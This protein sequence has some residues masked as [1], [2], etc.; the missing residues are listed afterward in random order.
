MIDRADP[1]DRL[2]AAEE[3]FDLQEIAVA[4]HGLQWRD[5]G[6]RAQY[7]EAVVA[8]LLGQLA[9]IDLEGG[10]GLAARARRPAQIAPVGGIADQRLVATRELLGEPRDDRLPLIALAFRFGLV[11]AEDVAR[12]A[13]LDLFDE[14]LGLA[15]HPLNEQWRQRRVV[16]EH[17]PAD[18]G[19]AALASAENVLQLAL[20]QRR[21]CGRRDHAAVGDDADPA[22]MKALAQTVDDRQQYGGIG[23]VARQH[24]GADRPAVAVDDD[25]QDHLLQIGAMVLGVAISPEPLA[26]SAVERQTGRVHEDQRQIAKQIAAALEQ[27]LLDQILDAARRQLAGC[28]GRDFLAEPRHCPVE[29]VQL[30]PVDPGN[31][32]VD[33]PF[34][35]AAVRARHE[36]PMQD[37]GEDGALDG[38]LKT[39]ALQELAH[40]LG[41]AEPL[42]EAPKQQ[43]AA[44]ARAGD[45]ARLH[46]GQDDGAIA[47]ARQRLGQT[48]QF[49]ARQQHVL[50]AERTDD[51]LANAAALALVLDEVEIGMASRRLLADKHRIVVRCHKINQK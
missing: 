50:T 3:V 21:N 17:K 47:M 16:L 5:P 23:G 38:E 28:G 15:P 30:Q 32:I 49:T 25:S 22:D 26:A 51:P 1:Q 6:V 35:A 12:R 29:V 20:L 37:T 41:N 8:R 48:I 27:T 40:Y 24:L 10:A 39:A 44:N 4:Q 2:G 11:A 19:A 14:E 7:E 31:S 18:D 34:L 43:R 45:A 33:H 13:D 9:R 46:V 42:P 36:Q